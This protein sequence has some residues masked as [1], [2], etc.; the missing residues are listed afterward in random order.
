MNP[1]VRSL[2]IVAAVL[3]GLGGGMSVP[4]KYRSAGKENCAKCAKKIP[5]GRA[6]RCCEE[7]RKEEE[8]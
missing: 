6:G 8:P 4:R 5:P 7:C 2:A 1:Q 3:G